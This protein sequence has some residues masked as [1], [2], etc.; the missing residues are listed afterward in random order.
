[1]SARYRPPYN[2]QDW[3]LLP[4]FITH[5]HFTS[6]STTSS[7][8]SFIPP[9]LPSYTLSHFPLPGSYLPT[10]PLL[11]LPYRSLFPPSHRSL[12]THSLHPVSLPPVYPDP[13]YYVDPFTNPYPHSHLRLPPSST[14]SYYNILPYD[15]STLPPPSPTSTDDLHLPNV[16]TTPTPVPSTPTFPEMNEPVFDDDLHNDSSDDL[17]RHEEVEESPLP[18]PDRKVPPV[19][20]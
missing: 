7:G 3:T 14:P 19:T 2:V 1:M 16:P 6:P 4:H 13:L 5:F 15:L 18:L 12:L 8:T 20:S 10:P 17:E 9:H 11:H